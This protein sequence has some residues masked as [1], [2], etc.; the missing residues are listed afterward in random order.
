MKCKS[1]DLIFSRGSRKASATHYDQGA[2]FKARC[3][4]GKITYKNLKGS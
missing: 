3:E 4:E 2:K 1:L